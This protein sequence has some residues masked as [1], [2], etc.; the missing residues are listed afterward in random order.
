MNNI[1]HRGQAYGNV[2]N[3]KVIGMDKSKYFQ[4]EE[5][6]EVQLEEPKDRSEASQEVQDKVQ[7]VN[8]SPASP[9]ATKREEFSALEKARKIEMEANKKLKDAE[10]L[11]QAYQSG[12]I[13]RIAKAQGMNT[14]EYVRWVNAK[15]I[16]APTSKELTPQ[17]QAAQAAQQWKESVD[18]DRTDT[19]QFVNSLKKD[20]YINKN[21]LP[22]LIKN[23]DTYEFIHDKGIDE[24]CSF[25]YDFMNEHFN[26]T[27]GHGK[28]EELD[29]VELFND[30]ES[31]YMQ[32]WQDRQEKAKKFKKLQSKTNNKLD[33][34]AHPNGDPSDPNRPAKTIGAAKS[35][36]PPQTEA[37]K[38]AQ[39]LAGGSDEDSL[40]ESAPS[41]LV[42]GATRGT[43]GSNSSSLPAKS[44]TSGGTT[45]KGSKFSREARLAA[46]RKSAEE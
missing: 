46:M 24:V 1:I 35:I 41:N 42:A 17:E 26:E 44:P 27:G 9:R 32:E 21:L 14:T 2:S 18:R 36:T 10:N 34:A 28:G 29:P 31:Q 43:S 5:T 37:D 19:N 13:D 23:P 38:M 33:S 7:E 45:P 39:M 3:R 22:H 16:G 30:L 11:A 40:A 12:D 8:S 4:P 6:E 20:S 25:I 15:A